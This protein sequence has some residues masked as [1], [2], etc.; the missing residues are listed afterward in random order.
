MRHIPRI[1]LEPK[2][3][4]WLN[5]SQADSNKKRDSGTFD[6]V[7]KWNSTRQSKGVLG[8]LAV[9][10]SMAGPTERCMY[11]QDS[12]GSDIE[13]F[14]PKTSFLDK[15]YLWENLLLCCTE[16]GRHKGE[17]FPLDE[18]G[19]PLLIDPTVD[20]PWDFMDYVPETGRITARYIPAKGEP[21]KHGEKTVEILHLDRREALE[22]IYRRANDA[23]LQ[24]VSELLRTGVTD[25]VT[26]ANELIDHDQAGLIGWYV[27]GSGQGEEPFP[28]LKR[29]MPDLWSALEAILT[30]QRR[31]A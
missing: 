18:D 16:C 30:P 27:T 6:A 11:C 21:S 8:A 12:H 20:N 1:P 26:A 23:L 9:L 10:K 15:M 13:H 28:R 29:D 4:A 14:W 3:V 31:E 17:Q 19:A 24:R 5:T 25:T 7:K 2:V 22:K